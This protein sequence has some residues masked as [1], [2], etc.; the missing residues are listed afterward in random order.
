MDTPAPAT[1]LRRVV[2]M[3]G[4]AA[5]WGFDIVMGIF[6]ANLVVALPLGILSYFIGDPGY[7]LTA[8]DIVACVFGV[9]FM[10][11][12]RAETGPAWSRG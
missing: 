11:R 1:G 4:G 9:R 2:G 10:R 7:L 6:L 12:A 8:A 5:G 3:G